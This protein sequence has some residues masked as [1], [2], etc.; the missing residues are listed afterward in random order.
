MNR[1]LVFKG[2]RKYYYT[3]AIIFIAVILLQ[4]FQ[5][6]PINWS[7]TYNKKDKIAFGCYAVFNLLENTY[8]PF[9]ESNQQDMYN[10]NEAN[11]ENGQTLLIIN[12]GVNFSK[13]EV[14]SLFKFL[15]KGNTVL[16]CAN[17]FGKA[18]SDTFNLDL[19]MNVDYS[20]KSLDS[21]LKK[22]AFEISYTQPKNNILKTY[23]YP[24]V[25]IESYFLKIDTGLFTVVSENK[26]HKPVVLE[27]NIGKGKL[28]LSSLPDVFGNIF[29]ADNPNRN[30]AYTLLTNLKNK[31]II[32]DEYYK[33]FG[34]EQK[35][36]FSFIFGSDAL[37]MA[38]SIILLGLLFFMIFE[39]KRKQRVIPVINPLQ[40]STLEFVEVI[41][42]VYFNSNNHKHIAE[43]TIKYFYFD[44]GKKFHV[45]TTVI[46]ERFFT[47]L[48]NLSG[49]GIDKIKTLFTYCE[50]LKR[51]P[52]L[53]Q[54]DLLELNDRI[55]NF[56]Q[57]SIR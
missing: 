13:L 31:T 49:I 4:Y 50:N 2:N 1:L 16:V 34:K 29:I 33:T 23:T 39:L 17:S 25:A 3:L 8:A 5:P 18:L 42:R 24:A 38:Y 28:V 53:T 48:S 21:L 46:D 57:Q 52:S 26:K 37:Y 20:V 55:T 15:K 10:L 7:R 40:N 19:E 36:I 32:W 56:K 51:A 27:A 41:S 44:I 11:N 30:Y 6:K 9:I 22:P 47:T 54:Y 12:D 45:N 14:Q 35:G 43:E